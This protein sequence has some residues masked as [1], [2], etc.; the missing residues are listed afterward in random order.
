MDLFSSEKSQ[1]ANQLKHFIHFVER[2]YERPVKTLR[3]DRGR[4]FLSNEFSSWLDEKGITH[5]LSVPY[6]PQQN[7]VAER[8]NRT[9]T[10]KAKAMLLASG[11]HPQF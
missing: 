9:V 1:A 3:T 5:D 4:E 2:Q 10:G 11:L 7:G 6:T 8:Y